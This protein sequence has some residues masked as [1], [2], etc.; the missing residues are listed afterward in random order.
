M[1]SIIIPVY[2]V[3]KYLRECLD[4][5]L[6]QTY[7][8]FEVWLIDDGST[9]NSCEICDE[10]V[11]KYGNFHVI[12]KT[13]AGLGM[14]RNT[15]IE[16]ANGEY[17]TFLDSDDYWEKDMLETLI[18]VMQEKKVDICK[19]G[20]RRVNNSHEK[21]MEITYEN[22]LYIGEQA[23]LGLLPRMI[24]S[25]PEYSDSIE[26]AVCACLYKA[27]IIKEN[28]VRFP[29]ER[30]LISEDLIF[31]IEV[32][33]FAN[34]AIT[35]QYVGY[36]YRVNQ[37]S[38]TTQFRSDRF[39]ACKKLYKYVKTRLDELGYAEDAHLR[40]DRSFFVYLRMCISQEK[41]S[42]S[43]HIRK[44]RKNNI[45][46][47]CIDELVKKCIAN[48]PLHCLGIKQRFFIF[49]IELKMSTVL[50]VLNELGII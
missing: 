22:E 17:I 38:L 18:R 24:G 49:L 43:G 25:C 15:G 45:K 33:Q 10:Y 21:I 28:N 29:S 26:M 34:G 37:G 9:D 39:V 35:L 31:N 14:A 8:D 44:N 23:R 7:R 1:I 20:F 12:H 4:S 42:V 13:N 5:V 6:R 27:K 47:I 11:D 30:N 40:L 50:D 46:E 36:C 19:S 32:M 16:N 3:E 2:N 48:Y 41:K